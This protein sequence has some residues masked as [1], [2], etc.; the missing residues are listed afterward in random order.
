V[1]TPQGIEPPVGALFWAFTLAWSVAIL[2]TL[3]WSHPEQV[4]HG[5]FEMSSQHR[6]TQCCSVWSHMEG[7]V[8]HDM[9]DG[10]LDG[11]ELTEA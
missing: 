7:K 5:S 1:R 11:H 3:V 2:L 10:R 9:N 4:K 8:D 6:T